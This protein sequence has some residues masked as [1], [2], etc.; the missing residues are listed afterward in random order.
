MRGGGPAGCRSAGWFGA[1][2]DATDSIAHGGAGSTAT[3]ATGGGVEP[4][5]LSG[6]SL[7]CPQ[8]CGT[9]ATVSDA[10]GASVWQECC[11]AVVAEAAAHSTWHSVTASGAA[12]MPKLSARTSRRRVI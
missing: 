4:S 3:S 8:A 10:V 7:L 9:P 5:M 11:R 2:P 1:V 6:A 12:V